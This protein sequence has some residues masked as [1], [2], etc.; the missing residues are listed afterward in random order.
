MM[1]ITTFKK[2]RIGK[3]YTTMPQGDW[4]KTELKNISDKA[5][6]SQGNPL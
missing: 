3:N 1:P 5:M 6:I 2:K 4:V